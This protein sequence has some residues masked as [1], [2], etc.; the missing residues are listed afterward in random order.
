M[1]SYS[2]RARN[3]SRRAAP[4]SGTYPSLIFV[5]VRNSPC[6]LP[7]WFL[8]PSVTSNRTCET[9][10]SAPARG[11]TNALKASYGV[12]PGI[13][14]EHCHLRHMRVAV[15]PVVARLPPA[16][17]LL[18]GHIQQ[19]PRLLVKDISKLVLTQLSYRDDS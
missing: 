4:F 10:F 15:V 3:S 9:Q 11:S 8:P 1:I 14:Q 17:E 12:L 19:P 5:P 6:I 16:D 18:A 13:G 2:I 7:S